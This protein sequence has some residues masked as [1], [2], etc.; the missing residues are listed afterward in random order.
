[1]GETPPFV[2]ETAGHF[3]GLPRFSEFLW[4][5]KAGQSPSNPGE[6]P[7]SCY[8]AAPMSEAPPSPAEPPKSEPT[9]AAVGPET[10]PPASVGHPS[11]DGRI[12]VVNC[13]SRHSANGNY[14]NRHSCGVP[15]TE[16]AEADFNGKSAKLSWTA[17][18]DGKKIDSEIYKVVVMLAKP[19]DNSQIALNRGARIR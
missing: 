17:G 6:A 3:W 9:S 4:R 10:L 1:M 13:V 12:A 7:R 16:R 19:G 14:I 2:Q 8:V 18:P 15:L 5:P 11:R